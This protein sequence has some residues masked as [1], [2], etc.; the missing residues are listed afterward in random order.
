[1]KLISVLLIAFVLPL[2]GCAGVDSAAD[3][4]RDFED[5]PRNYI[6]FFAEDSA[7]LDDA[8]RGVI[9]QA[10]QDSAQVQP[11]AIHIAGLSGEGPQSRVSPALAERRFS[12]VANALAAEGLDPSLIARSEL[13][14][15]PD[16]PDFAVQ[17]IE[18]QFELP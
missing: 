1:M 9:A 11:M 2:A 7:A 5:A 14:D 16:L 4:P 17:R 15:D 18:I 3:I 8:A 13:A 10:A 6:V 12:A